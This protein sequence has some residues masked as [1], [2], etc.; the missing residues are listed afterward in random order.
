MFNSYVCIYICTTLHLKLKNIQRYGNLLKK[1]RVT[2]KYLSNQLLHF[3]WCNPIFI[4]S[5]GKI[6]KLF[7]LVIKTRGKKINSLGLDYDVNQVL[8]R[9]SRMYFLIKKISGTQ[10]LIFK[11]VMWCLFHKWY[12]L[13]VYPPKDRYNG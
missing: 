3:S 9:K 4:Y 11:V 8:R 2:F 5:I 7:Q 13:Q 1:C 10:C 12:F 6:Y